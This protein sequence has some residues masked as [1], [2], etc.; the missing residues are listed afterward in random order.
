MPYWLVMAGVIESASPVFGVFILAVEL[1]L[2][3]T[4]FILS[5]ISVLKLE[6]RNITS[7]LTF[8]FLC[9]IGGNLAFFLIGEFAFPH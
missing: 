3:L 5:C 7:I 9:L 4:A 1:V 2:V 6:E 8:I